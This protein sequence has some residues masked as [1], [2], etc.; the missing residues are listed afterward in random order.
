[1]GKAKIR[2]N[3]DFSNSDGE[4]ETHQV[5]VEAV[6]PESGPKLIDNV[7]K[8]ILKANKEAIR[9][10]IVLYFEELSKKKP[11]RSKELMEV[12]SEQILPPIESMGK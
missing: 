9:Q 1:M 4:T 10:A 3:I 6:L 11:E 2:I 12:L 7:E 5:E 8:A